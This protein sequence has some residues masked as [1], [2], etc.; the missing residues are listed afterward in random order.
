MG[1]KQSRLNKINKQQLYEL[2][3]LFFKSTPVYFNT[4]LMFAGMIK[5]Q[6]HLYDINS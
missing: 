2:L 1:D 4:I 5:L 3:F 6:P